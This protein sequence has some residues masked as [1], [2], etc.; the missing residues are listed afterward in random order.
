MTTDLSVLTYSAHS[1]VTLVIALRAGVTTESALLSH[2]QGEEMVVLPP[3]LDLHLPDG[4][5]LSPGS[6]GLR[7]ALLQ[8]GSLPISF[9]ISFIRKMIKWS[10]HA[11]DK[12]K[13]L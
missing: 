11:L 12:T 3:V 2:F 7:L 4:D 5:P 1:Q 13:N 10:F 8:K 9:P 6:Q